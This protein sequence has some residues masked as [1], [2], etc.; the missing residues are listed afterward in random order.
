MTKFL[1]D[2]K[3]LTDSLFKAAPFSEMKAY[4]NVY[5]LKTPSQESGT[6][7]P[8]ENIFRNTLYNSTFYTF[9]ISRYLTT[10]DM[11][12]IHD[13]AAVVPYDQIIVLVNSNRYG[14]GGFYNYLN[15]CAAGNKLSTR[16]FIHEFGHSFAGLGDEYYTSEVAF[17]DYYN[18]KVEPWEPNLTTLVDFDSKW[19]SMVDSATPIPTPRYSDYSSKTGAFEGGGYVAKGIYSPMEDCR[20]KSNETPHFCPVC[21]KGNKR[22]D[23]L[24]YKMNDII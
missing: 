16:V 20:M 18:L 19:K 22:G 23:S 17:E 15:V 4:F 8:G 21:R 13:K 2:A 1:K 12:T 7:V 5:A 11:K 9:D 24:E 3:S 14:G 10:S 6:D